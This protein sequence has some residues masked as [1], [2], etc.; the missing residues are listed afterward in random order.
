VLSLHQPEYRIELSPKKLPDPTED[1]QKAQDAP[2]SKPKPKPSKA[3]SG[4]P[5]AASSNK[6]DIDSDQEMEPEAD[7]LPRSNG[8]PDTT[9]SRRR[10]QDLDHAPTTSVL[11]AT[12]TTSDVL[13][14]PLRRNKKDPVGV[15]L[16]PGALGLPSMPPPLTP[17]VTQA[18]ARAPD[19]PPPPPLPTGLTVASLRSR[20]DGKKKIKCVN[21][22]KQ[23]FSKTLLIGST[24]RR[25][26]ILTPSEMET[27]TEP[28]RP[29]RSIGEQT[30]FV[31]LLL[32]SLGGGFEGISR[33][34]H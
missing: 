33:Y 4:V 10:R 25:G 17:S 30:Q 16:T 23:K 2:K 9:T 21:R 13:S 31:L 6:I 15:A 11:P 12:T 8:L 3:K 20:L 18:L 24:R 26:A 27:L 34:R 5:R 7:E 19:A 28:W 32:F 22:K 14:T 29:Y 1:P